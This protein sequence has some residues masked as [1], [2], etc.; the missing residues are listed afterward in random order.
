ML[1][2]IDAKQ[3]I[4]S[5]AALLSGNTNYISSNYCS[6]TGNRAYFMAF[7]WTEGGGDWVFNLN[8]NPL[9]LHE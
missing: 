6:T 4:D 3:T 8:L 9:I 2:C 5:C 7:P 1:V